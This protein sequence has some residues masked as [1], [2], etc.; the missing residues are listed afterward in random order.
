ML[1]VQEARRLLNIG[2]LSF[3][4]SLYHVKFIHRI[5][6]EIS[7]D[8]TTGYLDIDQNLNKTVPLLR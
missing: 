4:R 5:C 2:P 6:V 8:K 3:L 1:R 7:E